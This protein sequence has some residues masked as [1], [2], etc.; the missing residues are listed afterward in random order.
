VDILSGDEGEVVS[1]RQT[2]EEKTEEDSSEIEGESELTDHDAI[3]ENLNASGPITISVDS[4]TD[5]LDEVKSPKYLL[6]PKI[7]RKNLDISMTSEIISPNQTHHDDSIL[8]QQKSS[9]LV[10]NKDSKIAV[11]PSPLPKAIGLA[12]FGHDIL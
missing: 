1:V 6:E 10:R 8:R 2:S 7:H 9:N 3:R 11:S 12:A 4:E 5:D